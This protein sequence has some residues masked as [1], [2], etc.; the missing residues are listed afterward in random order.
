MPVWNHGPKGTELNKLLVAGGGASYPLSAA[1]RAALS[2]RLDDS[3]G[4]HS[5]PRT[6]VWGC[7]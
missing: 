6:T 1:Y 5:Q 3:V 7:D 4:G 2:T